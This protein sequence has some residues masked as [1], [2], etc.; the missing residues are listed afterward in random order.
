MSHFHKN[1]CS[2]QANIDNLECLLHDLDFDFDIIPLSETWNPE[3]KKQLFSPNIMENCHPYKGT[4]GTTS[5]SGTGLFIHKDL[6]PLP[7]TDLEFKV[8]KEDEE[9]ESCWIEIANVLIGFI[10]RHPPGND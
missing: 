3:N 6:N 4:T 9:F 1:I 10:Y 5:K 8:F 2:L 7:R